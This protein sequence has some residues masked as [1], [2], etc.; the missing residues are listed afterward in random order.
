MYCNPIVYY[1]EAQTIERAADERFIACSHALP[2]MMTETIAYDRLTVAARAYMLDEPCE[3][4]RDGAS[5]A[6]NKREDKAACIIHTHAPSPKPFYNIIK[7]R[8]ILNITLN[9][10]DNNHIFCN[11]EQ[12][13][14]PD[15]QGF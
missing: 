12:K 10:R 15:L 9:L 3:V 7:K 5:A 4:E 2:L 8:Y 14:T 11:N 1:F 6:S 13:P